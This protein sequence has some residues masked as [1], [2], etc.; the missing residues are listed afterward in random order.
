MKLQVINEFFRIAN[1]SLGLLQKALKD[2]KCK[3]TL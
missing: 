2:I 3:G 1:V